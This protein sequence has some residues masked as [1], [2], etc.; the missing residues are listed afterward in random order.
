MSASQEREDVGYKRRHGFCVLVT[1]S[2]LLA[3]VPKWD[4]P[5]RSCE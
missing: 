3:K 2:G 5:V 1:G 4:Y